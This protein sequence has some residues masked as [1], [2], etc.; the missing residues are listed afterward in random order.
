MHPT[1]VTTNS[2][3][4]LII[5]IDKKGYKIDTVSDMLSEERESFNTKK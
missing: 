5:E 1:E 3:E 2:L 4:R